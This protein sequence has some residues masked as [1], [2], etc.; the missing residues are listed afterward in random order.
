MNN[1]P[2]GIFD[3]GIGGLTVLKELRKLLPNEDV[4]YFGDTARVPYGTKSKKT[5]TKYAFQIADF[6]LRQNVKLIVVACN[7]VSSN[8]LNA[9]KRAYKIP[10]IGVIEPGVELALSV[11][12]NKRIGVIGTSATINSHKYKLLLNKK[13]PDVKVFEKACPLFVPLIESGFINSKITDLTVEYYLKD[14]KNKNIDTLILGCT[15]YPL[16]TSA[17]KKFMGNINIINSGYAV[18]LKV[19]NKLASRKIKSLHKKK[20][21]LRLFLSD[22]SDYIKEIAPLIMNETNLKF[23]QKSLE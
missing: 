21:K 17:I 2:I 13:S 18:A 20:G 15:H 11:S 12:K 4:I 3:S 6:L 5:I 19:K 22:Y 14:L 7:T 16:L 23:I 9:L 8:S 10:I 1:Q